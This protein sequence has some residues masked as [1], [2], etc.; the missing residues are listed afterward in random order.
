M[1]PVFSFT[2]E[3]NIANP[4]VDGRRGFMDTPIMRSSYDKK[5]LNPF[6]LIQII[7]T[8]LIPIAS[9]TA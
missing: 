1:S 9:K 4:I 6:I 3:E 5:V 7:L 2:I 8:E